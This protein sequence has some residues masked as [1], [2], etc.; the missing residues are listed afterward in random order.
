MTK[1]ISERISRAD[2]VQL[3][4]RL[5]FSEVDSPAGSIIEPF[6]LLTLDRSGGLPSCV[7]TPRGWVREESIVVLRV[8]FLSDE[9]RRNFQW[10]RT[11]TETR[12]VFT[13]SHPVEEKN[14]RV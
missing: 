6:F 12:E 3:S 8:P 7:T 11:D 2:H 4:R 9:C 5:N 1:K 14:F 13:N 10:R